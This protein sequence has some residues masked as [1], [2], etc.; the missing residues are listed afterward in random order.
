MVMSSY[1]CAQHSGC[2][3]GFSWKE[4][5]CKMCEFGKLAVISNYAAVKM[6]PLVTP[7][8]SIRSFTHSR[9]GL[10]GAGRGGA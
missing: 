7:H 2:K 1:K 9:I 6:H 4:E 5:E 8:P 10:L 3:N